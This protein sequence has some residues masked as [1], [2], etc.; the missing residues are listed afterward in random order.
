MKKWLVTLLCL[1]IL[2]GCTNE[3]RLESYKRWYGARAKMLYG[4]ALE[5]LKVGQ[6]D[7]AR[8]KAQEALTLDPDFAP[9][10]LL[11]AKVEIEQG[12]YARAAERLDRLRKEVPD[13]AEVVY[14]YGVA[15]EKEGNLE[16]ALDSYRQSHALD[17]EN[18]EGVTAAGEVLV[19]MDRLDQAEEYVSGY[20]REAEN[21]PALYEL[22]G[23]IALM[24]DDYEQA[25]AR[26]RRARDSDY[27]NPFYQEWLGRAQYM[28]GEY[29]EALIT[30][31]ELVLRPEYDPPVWVHKTRGDCHMA[32]GQYAQARDAYVSARQCQPDNAET[33]S[34]IAK[35]ALA[36]RDAP[37]AIMAAREALRI[38]PRCENAPMILGYALLQEEQAQEAASAL[39]A[40]VRVHPK[41]GT[42]HCLLGRALE[43]LGDNAAAEKCYRAAILVD[44][45]NE[46]ART[47]L[48]SR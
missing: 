33:W 26:F 18:L 44:P 25:V 30:L 1:A 6:L 37:R 40:A 10:A 13:N 19:A 16:I 36:L 12:Q 48:A 31:K 23:R 39:R 9:G 32:L 5:H 8:N 15:Q 11:L 47:L 46:L 34:D 41:N 35:A 7:K 14:L 38:D 45:E 27:D 21:D 43:A 22:A 4:V 24:L 20:L 42:L 3:R 2:A 28:A 17:T 29:S